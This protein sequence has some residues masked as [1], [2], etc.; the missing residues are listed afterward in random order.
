MKFRQKLKKREEQV[1]I[2]KERIEILKRMIN[3][4]PE[5]KERYKE[6]IKRISNKYK[7][8]KSF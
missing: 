8:E 1:E 2:A 5:L 7:L 6:L 3:E 4:E